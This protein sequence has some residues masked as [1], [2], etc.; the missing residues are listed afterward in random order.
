MAFN[1]LNNS[2]PGFLLGAGAALLINGTWNYKVKAHT[3]TQKHK[4][5]HLCKKNAHTRTHTHYTHHTHHTTYTTHTTHHTHTTY[6]I[7]PPHVQ[8][9]LFVAFLGPVTTILNVTL[10]NLL[11]PKF[12]LPPLTTSFVICSMTLLACVQAS[13]ICLFINKLF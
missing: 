12:R 10:G 6:D 5:M 9:L 2:Y 1:P 11:I 3:Y 13:S 7:H 8:I 4:R